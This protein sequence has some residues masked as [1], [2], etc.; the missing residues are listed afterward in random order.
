[1]GFNS[2]FKG[3]MEEKEFKVRGVSLSLQRPRFNLGPVCVEI[4]WKKWH[5][6][7]V[8]SKNFGVPLSV[9]F[10]QFSILFFHPSLMLCNIGE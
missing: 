3:L 9:S 5:W 10:H 6:D 2:A 7:R 1:M 8:S 4:W